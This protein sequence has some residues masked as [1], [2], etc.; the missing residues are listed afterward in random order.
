MRLLGCGRFASRS[1][2]WLGLRSS[3]S[4]RVLS[5]RILC[6][7]ECAGSRSRDM[8]NCLGLRSSRSIRVFSDCRRCI[9]HSRNVDGSEEGPDYLGPRS[10]SSMSVI[11]EDETRPLF[12]SLSIS[13]IRG[14]MLALLIGVFGGVAI[15]VCRPHNRT[16]SIGKD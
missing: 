8:S 16:G 13:G 3:R 9:L 4:I 12:H 1:D 5:G 2:D 15:G 6:C 7:G 10:S 14:M 11:S